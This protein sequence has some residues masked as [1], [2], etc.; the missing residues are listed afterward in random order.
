MFPFTTLFRS[1]RGGPRV[2]SMVRV[3]S[4]AEEEKRRPCRERERLVA[5]RLELANRIESLLCLHGAAGF[6]PRLKKATAPLAALRDFAGAPLP[7]QTMAALRRLMVRHRL[8]S[9]Q[10][11][12]LEAERDRVLTVARTDRGEGR[13]RWVLPQREN[14]RAAS[15]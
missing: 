14:R 7:E 8:A 11:S 4:A 9:E 12:A 6:K 15:K 1:L 5:E 13:N 3:P 10:L 2:C